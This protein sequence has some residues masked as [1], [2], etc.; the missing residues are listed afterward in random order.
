MRM[1]SLS[2]FAR[3]AGAAVVI[4]ALASCTAAPA[5]TPSAT[6]DATE[7][8]AGS[9]CVASPET[10]ATTPLPAGASEPLDPAVVDELR[11][12]AEAGF[13]MASAPGAVVGVQTPDGTW[14]EAFGV[15]D[16][17]TGTPLEVD[18]IFRIGSITKTFTGSLVLQL[19]ESGELS[20]DDTI[21]QYVD[22]VPNGDEVTIRML[23]NMTSGIA[24]YGLNE[25]WVNTYETAPTTAWTPDQLLDAGFSVSPL[26]AP[27]A[28]FNYSNTNFILLGEVIEEVTGEP[29][30]DVLEA[31]I[32]EP[33]SLTDTYF[34]DSSELPD[35]HP[36]GFSLQ[37]TP[38]DSQ[39]PVD[40]TDW[41]PTAA[42]TAGQI[43]STVDDMLLWGHALVTGQGI[44]DEEMS[45][46]RL[47]SFP[48]DEGY[49][50]AMGCLG[51]WVGHT[52]EIAGFNTTV[53][54]DTTSDTTVIVIVTSDIPSGD[55]T[56][57]KTLADNTTA[58]PCM[59]PA[60][61]IFV[62]LS[63]ALGHPFTPIPM[64]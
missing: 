4:A 5:A 40:A 3:I 21:D 35:P 57:S 33:L 15:A 25:D 41:S 56:V 28:E 49:G 1:T 10:V 59:S 9:T 47:T 54:H 42:W 17:A 39:E 2:S 13:D 46:E 43:V 53:Y 36:K 29:Y 52:G 27:G 22:G 26:F 31:Q 60:T 23:L 55:C 44:L 7:A 12:A 37:G 18:D 62:S 38:D 64:S 58:M 16:P 61:R 45:I 50:Y 51:G 63:K 24:S 30:P 8:A 34:P 11:L 19:V 32:L 14:T 20:L 6:S 48:E